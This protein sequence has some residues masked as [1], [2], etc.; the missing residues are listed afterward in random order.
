[1]LPPAFTLEDLP[2]SNGPS[3][4][5]ARENWPDFLRATAAMAVVVLHCAGH[6]LYLYSNISA[7]SWHFAN[8]TDSLVR[9]SVPLF[10]MLSGYLLLRAPVEPAQF[11]KRHLPRV[12]IPL[13]AWSVAC[14]SYT[15]AIH[16]PTKIL[17]LFV[18]DRVFYHLWFLYAI[19]GCYLFLPVVSWTISSDSEKRCRYILVL[20][21]LLISIPSVNWIF[22]QVGAG[23]KL[24]LSVPTL[25]HYLGY[26][27]AGH[28]LANRPLSTKQSL[29]LLV[30]GFAITAAGTAYISQSAGSFKGLFYEYGSPNV[31]FMALGLFSLS[32]LSSPFT[33]HP[34]IRRIS[35]CSLGIY[36]LHPIILESCR[37]HFPGIFQYSPFA[38]PLVALFVFGLSLG[39]IDLMRRLPYLQ[40]IV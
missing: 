25:V 10:F 14:L 30:A 28:V 20:W 34:I 1:M 24:P 17:P 39:S 36:L 37:A 32:R 6:W 13:V 9:A 40:K 26:F 21:S 23:T 8:V 12:L 22:K 19:A 27:V 4:A 33:H 11:L 5:P 31:A 35:D 7:V 2:V 16:N 15:G 29:S 38:T 18:S 3:P